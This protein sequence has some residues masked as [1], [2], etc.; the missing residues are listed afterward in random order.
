MTLF[1]FLDWFQQMDRR[2]VFVGMAFA[3]VLPLV[4]PIDLGFKVDDRVRALYDEVEALPAGSTVLMSADFDPASRPEL[5]PFYRANLEHLFRKDVKVVMVTLWEYAPQ[6]VKPILEEIAARHGKTWGEDYVFLGYLPGKEIAI[7]SVGENLYSA[8]PKAQ[9]PSDQVSIPVD[10]LPIMK[11]FKQAKDFPLLVNVSAGFPGTREYVLQIQGQY[12]LNIVS[13]CTAVSAPDYVPF[14]KA[15]QLSGLSGGMPGS[16]QYE[17]LVF[18]DGPP[19]GVRL[20]AMQS[21]NV[22][23]FGHFYI[24]ALIVFGNVAWL[25]TRPRDVAAGGKV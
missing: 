8:F 20:L 16:A 15:N 17:K 10:E 3:I 5:E 12:D 22:L 11:G 23:N 13:A 6:L 25:L 9:R 24:I 19:E 21:V 1:S 14:L 4:F 7:K 2:I 18:P